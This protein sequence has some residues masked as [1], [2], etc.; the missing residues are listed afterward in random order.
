MSFVANDPAQARRTVLQSSKR[1]ARA[2]AAAAADATA[3]QT[4]RGDA[5]GARM[6]AAIIITRAFVYCAESLQPAQVLLQKIGF[7]NVH[8]ADL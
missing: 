5:S 8:F 2:A 1:W 6:R 3:T 4:A 7:S